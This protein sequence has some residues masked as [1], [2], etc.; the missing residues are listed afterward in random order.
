[1]F[2]KAISIMNWEVDTDKISSMTKSLIDNT[3]ERCQEINNMKTK[4]VNV[5]K[6]LNEMERLYGNDM[7]FINIVKAVHPDKEIRD[8]CTEAMTEL[9]KVVIEIG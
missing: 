5:L 1:M 6:S 2:N 9:E 4:D 7:C 8:K 3:R